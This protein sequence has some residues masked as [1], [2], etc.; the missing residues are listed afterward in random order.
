MQLLTKETDY[1]VR[2]LINLSS[3]PE[4][5]NNAKLIAEKE[6]IPYHFLR[7]ILQRLGENGFIETKKGINGGI[8]LLRDPARIN[9]SELIELFQGNIELS[10]C[11]FRKN[12]CRNRSKC[13]LRKKIRTI[14]KTVTDEFRNITIE[15][16]YKGTME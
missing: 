14:E 4:V 12:I 6:D 1:A 11:M 13:V 2:A 15:S 7:R 8:K 3:N 10:S 16:L 5:Q 9:V